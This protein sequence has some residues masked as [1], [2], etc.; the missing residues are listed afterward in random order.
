MRQDRK[1]RT[2]EDRGQELVTRQRKRIR[3]KYKAKEH[4][5]GK[6]RLPGEVEFKKDMAIILTLAGYTHKE[7]ALSIGESDRTVTGWMNEDETKE[8]FEKIVKELPEAAKTLLETYQIE[9]VHTLVDIM[10]TNNDD[11]IVLDAVKEILD[12]G[13]LPKISRQ[14]RKN[15]NENTENFRLSDPDGIVE[16][17]RQAPPEVQE[18]AANIVEGLENLLARHAQPLPASD[19]GKEI[20]DAKALGTD[21]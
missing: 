3:R 12:R 8:K 5:G 18:E 21:G 4:K 14:E 17:I 11:K 6:P 19:E 10:R 9:A 2:P 16:R 7:I 1:S 13:G 15:E 20:E